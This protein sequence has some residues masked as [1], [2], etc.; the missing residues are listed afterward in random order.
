MLWGLNQNPDPQH[1]RWHALGGGLNLK[2]SPK[3]Q[4]RCGVCLVLVLWFVADALS[5]ASL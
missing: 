2:I 5:K 1:A 4:K 3:P